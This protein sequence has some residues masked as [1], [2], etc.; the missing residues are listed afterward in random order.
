MPDGIATTEKISHTLVPDVFNS[1]ECFSPNTFEPDKTIEKG[2]SS[3]KTCIQFC[4]AQ[5]IMKAVR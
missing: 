2:N 1:L 4:N 3:E 5:R